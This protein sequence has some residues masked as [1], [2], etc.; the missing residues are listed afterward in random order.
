MIAN[1][2][3]LG[4]KLRNRRIELGLSQSQVA[5]I[6]NTDEQYVYA[7]ENNHNKPIISMYPRIIE[8]LECFPFEIDTTTLGGRIK[9]YRYLHGMSQE[10]MAQFLTVDEGT[11]RS[12][13]AGKRAP[14]S[15]IMSKVG[16]LI[17]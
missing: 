9:K 6:L 5:K 11:L 2:V 12:Y 7:W 10:K 17:K 14:R 4:E 3:T 15:D 1:P 16:W 8:F 13:E